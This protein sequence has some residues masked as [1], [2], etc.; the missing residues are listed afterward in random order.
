MASTTASVWVSTSRRADVHEL[1]RDDGLELARRQCAEQAGADHERRAVGPASDD[2]RTREAV[3]DRGEL[4]WRGSRA[5]P[6]AARRSSGAAD[7]RP[8][9][10]GARRACRAA[11]GRR[12]RRPRSRRASSRTRRASP[13]AAR[14]RASRSRRAAPAST[15]TSTQAFARLRAPAARMDIYGSSSSSSGSSRS[16]LVEPARRPVGL[17]CVAPARAVQRRDV[18]QGHEDVPVQ[19]DVRDVLD[20]A[21]RREHALLVL[22]AEEREL[23]LLAFVLVR[24]VLHPAQAS[25]SGVRGSTSASAP[26]AASSSRPTFRPRALRREAGHATDQ[27]RRPTPRSGARS[28]TRRDVVTIWWRGVAPGRRCRKDRHRGRRAPRCLP[29]ACGAPLRR[30]RRLLAHRSSSKKKSMSGRDARL[31]AATSDTRST[32]SRKVRPR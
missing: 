12:P 28:P 26:G 4:R 23:D 21:V 20:R 15:S 1:V 16:T 14:R 32:P 9:R 27:E 2:E 22:A 10:A 17:G 25:G 6:T 24:V 31:G 18:L 29:A 3:G 19:L 8:R 5:A 13:R 11:R 7:P 30:A